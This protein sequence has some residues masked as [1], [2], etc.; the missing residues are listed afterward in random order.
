MLWYVAVASQ[1]PTQLAMVATNR[2]SHC[3]DKTTHLSIYINR[4]TKTGST[5][6]NSVT[7]TVNPLNSKSVH[8]VNVGGVATA[9]SHKPQHGALALGSSLLGSCRNRRTAV[10]YLRSGPAHGHLAIAIIHQM[11]M[12]CPPKHSNWPCGFWHAILTLTQSLHALIKL[13]P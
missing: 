3:R 13:Y 9:P 7:L 11:S 1:C 5:F 4:H 10:I 8:A 6:Y 12:P 2:S